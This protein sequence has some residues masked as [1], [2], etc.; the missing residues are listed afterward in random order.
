M[1]ERAVPPRGFATLIGGRGAVE[2]DEALDPFRVA[3][4]GAGGE[5]ADATGAAE[6]VEQ[7][8]RRKERVGSGYC[9]Q[10]GVPLEK[11]KVHGSVHANRLT[12]KGIC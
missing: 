9:G 10:G 8:R 4:L 11:G 5:R 2:A 3:D 12:G 7:A 6:A 1:R